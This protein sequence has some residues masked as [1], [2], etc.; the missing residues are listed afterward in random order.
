MK[1][2]KYPKIS[3]IIPVY[4]SDKFLKLLFDSI[5]KQTYENYELIVIDDGSTDRSAAILEDYRCVF[6]KKIKILNQSNRG[7]GAARNYGINL[8]IGEYVTFVDSDDYL[9]PDYL[10]KLISKAVETDSDIVNCG[11]YEVDEHAKIIKSNFCSKTESYSELGKFGLFI[12]CSQLFKASLL[13]DNHILFP[14]KGL[15]EDVIFCMKARLYS[16]KISSI[17]DCLYYYVQH[18]NSTMHRK[19]GNDVFPYAE[20]TEIMKLSSNI[21]NEKKVYFELELLSFYCGF[22]FKY[23][24]YSDI[25][26]LIPVIRYCEF[27]F[28]E[29]FPDY[30]GLSFNCLFQRISINFRRKLILCLFSLTLKLKML[31]IVCRVKQGVDFIGKKD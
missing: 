28:Q 18:E 7:Q 30:L 13:I 9:H 12:A 22:L 5:L 4:N 21:N 17:A 15:Y 3:V 10:R 31:Y 14:E 8:V 23:F 29:F 24:K 2:K 27:S 25:H 20:F 6:G 16:K 11:H 19:I 1:N 26:E